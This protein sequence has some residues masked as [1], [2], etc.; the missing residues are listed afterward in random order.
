MWNPNPLGLNWLKKTQEQKQ[1]DIQK[2][3]H[4]SP[5]PELERRI[6][7]TQEA[8][9]ICEQ[10]IERLYPVSVQEQIMVAKNTAKKIKEEI[11]KVQKQIENIKTKRRGREDRKEIKKIKEWLKY[12]EGMLSEEEMIKIIKFGK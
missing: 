2:Y 7:Q 1:E 9:K 11:A 10:N 3:F 12:E 6:K 5:I 8:I 4:K